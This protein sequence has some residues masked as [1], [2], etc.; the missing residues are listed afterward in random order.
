MAL[1]AIFQ[2]FLRKQ[3]ADAA[4]LSAASDVVT[5][6]PLVFGPGPAQH[7]LAHFTCYGYVKND[8]GQ[9]VKYNR[10]DLGVFFAD[11]YLLRA[12]DPGQVVTLLH[13]HNA[14]HA[15]IVSS[16]ICLGERFLAPGTPLIL[17]IQQAFLILTHHKWFGQGLNDE[18]S[19]WAMNNPAL[20]PADRRTLKR[21]ALNLDI[22]LVAAAVGGGAASGAK[23]EAA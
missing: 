11:D 5:I 1:N 8:D 19:R 2:R 17:I 9:I 16:H 4:A 14:F 12:P 3:A 6:T 10:W 7:F 23:E 20:L 22:Q 13:P 18:A 15:N 21:R